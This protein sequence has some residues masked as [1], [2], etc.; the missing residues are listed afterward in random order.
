MWK[1]IMFN[2][3]EPWPLITLEL[4][5]LISSCHWWNFHVL[6]FKQL[7]LFI[8]S[9]ANRMQWLSI[10]KHVHFVVLWMVVSLLV[11]HAYMS[12]KYI[13]CKLCLWMF[14]YWNK[15][16][17]SHSFVFLYPFN[18][19]YHQHILKLFSGGIWKIILIL[20]NF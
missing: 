3:V 13:R 16:V 18:S 19:P 2:I 6:P 11:L 10:T 9:Q 5:F 12:T 20:W 7:R 8:L 15:I 14:V 17:P 4:D 1:K